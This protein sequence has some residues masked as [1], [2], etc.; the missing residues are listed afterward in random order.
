MNNCIHKVFTRPLKALLLS[1]VGMVSLSSR[2]PAALRIGDA[3]GGGIV[4]WILQ[5]GDKGYAESVEQAIIVAKADASPT[6]YWSDTRTSTDKLE[7]LG[8]NDGNLQG[9]ARQARLTGRITHER[10]SP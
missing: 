8:Y 2:S 9:R 5:P 1:A 3:Y 6:L 10:N 4:A 7:G